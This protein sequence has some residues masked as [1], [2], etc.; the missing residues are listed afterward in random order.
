MWDS[1]V[2]QEG[3]N[4]QG[5]VRA[6]DLLWVMAEGDVREDR[7]EPQTLMHA[8]RLWRKWSK[9]KNWV[10]G[11]LDCSSV[12]KMVSLGQW[13]VLRLTDLLKE[14]QVPKQ[15]AWTR[16]LTMPEDW[17]KSTEDC[18][19]SKNIVWWAEGQPRGFYAS[20]SR[21]SGLC[22]IMTSTSR[23]QQRFWTKGYQQSI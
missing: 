22:I 18:V 8:W 13:G 19:L 2:L 5:I 4:Q 1:W 11:F 16:V 12:P 9:R 3:E 14:S 10:G 21:R 6:R 23:I 15:G 20:H 17:L 7:K